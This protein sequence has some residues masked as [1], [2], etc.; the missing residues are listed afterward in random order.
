MQKAFVQE[1]I[2]DMNTIPCERVKDSLL[3]EYIPLHVI[4]PD[5][6]TKYVLAEKIH[7][8]FEKLQ[9]KTNKKFED[10]I[11]SFMATLDDLV[12]PHIAKTPTAKKN[13]PVPVTP[14]ARKYYEKATS[15]KKSLKSISEL[16]DYT[17]LMLCLYTAIINSDEER[18]SNFDFGINCLDPIAIEASLKGEKE[19]TLF[20]MKNPKPRFDTSDPYTSDTCFFVIAIIMLYTIIGGS[21][22]ED[23][24]H[25]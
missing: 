23:L 11:K 19:A 18:I 6:A 3:G 7:D 5:T 24:S 21:L 13:E 10:Y 8:Y 20:G 15:I 17:R 25:E 14:R 12:E 16:I 1:T 4:T 2:L 9:Y 22:E